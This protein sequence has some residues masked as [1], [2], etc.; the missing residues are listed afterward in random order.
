MALEATETKVFEIREVG[1]LSR[2]PKGHTW[3]ECETDAG[4]VVFWGGPSATHLKQLQRRVPPFKVR[5]GCRQPLPNYPTHAW[6]VPDGVPLEF[7]EVLYDEPEE[8]AP[9]FS[10]PMPVN[11]PS[12]SAFRSLARGER[13]APPEVRPAAPSAPVAVEERHVVADERP[14]ISEER[15]LYVISG[16]KATIWEDDPDAE[17]AAFVPAVFA[18]RGRM[19]KEWLA[20]AQREKAK[21]WLFLSP[22]YGFIEPDHPVARHEASFSDRTSGPISDDALRVQ[23]EYQR[24]WNDRI[25]LN[26]FQLVYIWCDAVQYEERVRLAFELGGAKVVR[27]KALT[28]AKA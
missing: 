23:V 11:I 27:L 4:I 3:I 26:M 19:V 15:T 25:P 18:Y 10:R 12:A 14:G 6:W 5:C 21:Y 17:A 16:S 8:L 20:S 1:E 9:Q 13:S 2:S 7:V 24:R 28:R 22:R